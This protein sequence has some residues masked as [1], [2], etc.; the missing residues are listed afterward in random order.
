[1]NLQIKIFCKHIEVLL[2]ISIFKI[3]WINK[4]TF[5]QSYRYCKG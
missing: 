4:F 3:R 1:M 5:V 2:L